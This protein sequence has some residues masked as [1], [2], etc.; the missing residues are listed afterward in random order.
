M[1]GNLDMKNCVHEKFWLCNASKKISLFETVSHKIESNPRY[2]RTFLKRAY[3]TTIIL[4]WQISSIGG[5]DFS[6]LPEKGPPPPVPKSPTTICTRTNKSQFTQT[7]ITR[8][9]LVSRTKDPDRLCWRTWACRYS[10]SRRGHSPG[11]RKSK[12]FG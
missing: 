10:R 2:I 6:P 5:P 4:L 8:G 3:K 9:S 11:E 1:L 7:L 12:S